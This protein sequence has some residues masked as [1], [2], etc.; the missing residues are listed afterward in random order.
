MKGQNL[1]CKKERF[2]SHTFLFYWNKTFCF[3]VWFS[4]KN[5][6]KF[7]HIL[8]AKETLPKIYIIKTIDL[9]IKNNN[10]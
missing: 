10:F 3:R 8:V 9:K 4:H 6:K 2:A 7:F 1:L 5:L